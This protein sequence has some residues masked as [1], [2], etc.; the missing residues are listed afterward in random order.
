M[1]LAFFG[2]GTGELAIF[3]FVIFLL[4]GK[5]LPESLRGLGKSIHEFKKGAEEEEANPDDAAGRRRN[6]EK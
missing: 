5:R 2:I 3:A 4:Y 1:T 6:D